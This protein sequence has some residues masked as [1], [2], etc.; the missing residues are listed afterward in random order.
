MVPGLLLAALALGF[1]GLP[2]CGAMCSAPCLAAARPC[3][4]GQPTWGTALGVQVGRLTAYV[5]LGALAA[6]SIGFARLAA[7]HVE[8]L[9]PLWLMLQMGLLV[10]GL[11]LLARG[12]MPLWMD[13][14]APAAALPS[15]WAAR[16]GRSAKPWPAPVRSGLIG[17]AWGV[18]PCAQLYAA[19]LIAALAP[20]A[21]SG[22][23]VMVAF[24]LPAAGWF[25]SL[26]VVWRWWTGRR[27]RHAS[28]LAL[29]EVRV[30]RAGWRTR[31]ARWTTAP[32]W[33]I[34][35]AG[36][37]LAGSAGAMLV[38]ATLRPVAAWC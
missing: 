34:R 11:W 10:C 33:P 8:A 18:L 24:G 1:V 37:A 12:S 30:V 32:D 35:L 14:L 23:V 29:P 6:S 22:A 38:H 7:D 9:R 5:A 2:H 3:A 25:A 15:R 36:A 31:V 17:L 20:T 19:L 28:P 16:L 21:G 13:R 27:T 26:P 4:G